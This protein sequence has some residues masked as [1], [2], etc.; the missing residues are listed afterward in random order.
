MPDLEANNPVN[1]NESIKDL[2]T[3]EKEKTDVKPEPDTLD[4]VD[5]KAENEKPLKDSKPEEVKSEE[6][7]KEDKKSDPV[8]PEKKS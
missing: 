3:S 2:K 4:G 5:K 6:P 8:E 1:A 7:N